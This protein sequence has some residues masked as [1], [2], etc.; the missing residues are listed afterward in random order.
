MHAQRRV[1]IPDIAFSTSRRIGDAKNPGPYQEGGASSSNF[2]VPRLGLPSHDDQNWTFPVK[3]SDADS[4]HRFGTTWLF[5]EDVLPFLQDELYGEDWDI[6]LLHETMEEIKRTGHGEIDPVK[7][8]RGSS[9]YTRFVPPP[10]EVNE[11]PRRY[12]FCPKVSSADDPKDLVLAF[13]RGQE[14]SKNGPACAEA[15]LYAFRESVLRPIDRPSIEEES[16]SLLGESSEAGND[17]RVGSAP[18]IRGGVQRTKRPKR[19]WKP[20][21]QFPGFVTLMGVARQGGAL[22]LKNLLRAEAWSRFCSS[23]LRVGPSLTQPCKAAARV[24]RSF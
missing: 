21:A 19:T 11:D 23:I 8:I 6:G 12:N 10:Q 7:L 14:K 9:E 15:A 22:V 2:T 1:P 20:E 18:G 13:L 24:S 5:Q 4:Q 3:F 16:A 17:T